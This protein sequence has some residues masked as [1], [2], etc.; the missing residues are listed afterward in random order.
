MLI[1]WKQEDKRLLIASIQRL[2]LEEFDQEIGEIAAATVL[3][4]IDDEVATHYFNEGVRQAMNQ[5]VSAHARLEEDLFA[6]L[7]PIK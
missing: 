3:E 7:R 1:Q 2:F 4:F 6:L 5:E